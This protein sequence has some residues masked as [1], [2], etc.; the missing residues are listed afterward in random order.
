MDVQGFCSK[1]RKKCIS[2]IYLRF[3]DMESDVV[4]KSFSDSPSY[5]KV[6]VKVLSYPDGVINEREGQSLVDGFS[7][8]IISEALLDITGK[9]D[10]LSEFVLEEV[11][12]DL[13]RVLAR[14]HE[15]VSSERMT[16]FFAQSE[17]YSKMYSF[18]RKRQFRSFSYL[19]MVHELNELFFERIVQEVSEMIEKDGKEN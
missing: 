10:N 12:Q 3:P 2:Q 18:A 13:K 6:L 4:N 9:V 7:S 14:K 11:K 8:S 5:N 19:N 15:K 1:L 16:V 17:S